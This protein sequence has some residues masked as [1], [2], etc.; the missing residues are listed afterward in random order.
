MP[1]VAELVTKL[2]ADTK[3]FNKNINDAEGRMS[4]FAKTAAMTGAGIALAIGAVAVAGFVKLLDIIN[5]TESK[6]SSLVD[7]AAK[8]DTSVGGL[9][10]LGYIASLSG[11]SLSDVEAGMSK[12][13]MA[14]KQVDEGSKPAIDA[15]NKLGIAQEQLKGMKIDEV[16]LLVTE[17]LKGITNATDQAKVA[18]EIFGKA[19][20]S[21]I[22]I[23]NS[24]IQGL[25]AEFES[26]GGMLTNEQAAAVDNYGDSVAKL[27]VLFE[28]FKIQL[29]AQVAPALEQIVKW[30]MDTTQS[31]GGLG[32]V[33]NLTAQYFVAGL[34]LIV[35]GAQRVLDVIGAIQY[36]F[37]S[38]QLQV[39]EFMQ[40]WSE[41]DFKVFGEDLNF[42]RLDQITKLKQDLDN[43]S[44]A[45]RATDPLQQG[46]S[47]VQGKLQA[48][49]TQRVD[50][51]ITTEKGL[52]AE[53][54]E[55]PEVTAKI[56]QLI[57][58]YAE[59]SN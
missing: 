30:I 29:T 45:G 26:F 44:K 12:I 28:A 41:M 24:D 15:F 10:K 27:G 58:K 37:K 36:G 47:A 53:V 20:G 43:M 1:L 11:G 39:L 6:I 59:A 49:A 4:K 31:M 22:N 16:Y 55:S 34:Q 17:R 2:E 33:A 38:A 51:H 5:D 7:T 21:Q 25:S 54:A 40:A 35:D 3:N 57:E 32:P 50:V 56:N 48:N 18:A 52:K 42:E 8:F 13:L 9:Q 19:W 14:M 46:L 23:V